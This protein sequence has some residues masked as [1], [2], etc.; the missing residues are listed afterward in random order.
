MEAEGNSTEI[1]EARG[2]PIEIGSRTRRLVLD[3]NSL[4]AVE[5]VTGKNMLLSREWASPDVRLL[6]AVIWA[7]LLHD[8]P[9]LDIEEVGRWISEVGVGALIEPYTRARL[10][11]MPIGKSEGKKT[12]NPQKRGRRG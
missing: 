8:E 7:G 9:N 12:A 3:F 4:A 6:R 1:E 11:A 2:V 5:E 10:A